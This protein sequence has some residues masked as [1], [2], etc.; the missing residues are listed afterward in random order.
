MKHLNTA[1]GIL[2]G[3]LIWALSPTLTGLREPWDGA[4]T[5]YV[6]SLLLA[7]AVSALP[8]PRYWW[9][10]TIGVYAGQ[11]AFMFIAYGPGNLWPLSLLFGAVFMIVSLLG[12]GAVFG[13]WY[14]F[15]GRKQKTTKQIG[16]LTR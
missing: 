7:G 11:Y 14:L 15:A 5:Y 9:W 13:A 2:L 1:L 8:C 4:F 3:A 12:G 10:G 16:D 6:G